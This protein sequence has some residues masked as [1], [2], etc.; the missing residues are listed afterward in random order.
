MKLKLLACLTLTFGC[1]ASASMAD[2]PRTKD[3]TLNREWSVLLA[4]GSSS[5]ACK[6]RVDNCRAACQRSYNPGS[7]SRQGCLDNCGSKST[8]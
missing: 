6:K 7:S 8:C 1:V 5:D 2:P 3:E 4:Q